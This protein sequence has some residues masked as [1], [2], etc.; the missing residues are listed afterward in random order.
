MKRFLW[1]YFHH[2]GISLRQLVMAGSELA[3]FVEVTTQ[4]NSGAISSARNLLLL[5]A[6]KT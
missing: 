5:L 1:S 4:V 3:C 6:V 2:L